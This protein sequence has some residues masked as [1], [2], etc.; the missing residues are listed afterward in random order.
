MTNDVY[1]Q[2][3]QLDIAKVNEKIKVDY[4]EPSRFK[5]VFL[6]D[7]H[8]PMEF[9][10][11]LLVK[12]F[13]H[14]EETA[15]ALTMKIHEEGSGVVGVYSYEIAEE[16]AIETISVCRDNGFPLRIKLEEEA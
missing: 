2:K 9:V 7:D 4:K 6:N 10:V 11:M 5:V 3:E 1:K 12:L 14:S 16:K 15:H 13:K 8:T